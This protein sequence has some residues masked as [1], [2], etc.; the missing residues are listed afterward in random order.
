MPKAVVVFILAELLMFEKRDYFRHVSQ[1][2]NLENT[3]DCFIP[4]LLLRLL[5][6]QSISVDQVC[7]E[8]P[9]RALDRSPEY[10]PHCNWL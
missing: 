7:T 5:T 9:S 3:C 4:S 8:L 6:I 10:Q 2:N 1:K